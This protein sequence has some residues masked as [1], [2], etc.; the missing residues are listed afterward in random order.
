MRILKA[1]D[2]DG[3]NTISLEELKLYIVGKKQFQ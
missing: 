3:N 1:L 2:A